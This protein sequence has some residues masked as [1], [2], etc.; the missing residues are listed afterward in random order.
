MAFK[1]EVVV[2]IEPRDIFV[3]DLDAPV[4]LMEFGDYE[5]EVCAKVNEV[6]KQLLDKYEGKIK[7]NYRHFPLTRIHQRSLKA[8]ESAVAA[9]QEGKF[10]EMHNVLFAN[11]RHLGTTSLKLHSKEAGVKNKKF[12]DELVNATYGWQVQGD[13]KEGLDRG[14]KDVPT[15]FIND[16][17]F[18]GKPTLENLSKA[19][20][21]ALKKVK[22]KTAVKKRA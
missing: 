13:L 9:G 7:L 10:W 12:L 3:G 21:I 1:K 20:D 6:V 17:L 14:V 22:G 2:I 18:T 5:S 19:I 11:R 15:F 4:T 16:E 8:A